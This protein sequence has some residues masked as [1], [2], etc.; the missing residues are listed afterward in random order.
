MYAPDPRASVPGDSAGRRSEPIPV[1]DDEHPRSVFLGPYAR[2]GRGHG[3]G[4]GSGSDGRGQGAADRAARRDDPRSGEEGAGHRRRPGRYDR[5]A[6]PGRTGVRVHSCGAGGRVRR[7]SPESL[8][9]PDRRGCRGLSEGSGGEGGV[10][11]ADSGPHG[12]GDRGDPGIRGELRSYA[13]L[14]RRPGGDRT[15]RDHR[16]H[17]RGGVQAVGISIWRG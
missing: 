5:G 4:E 11:S 10:E 3:E 13:G 17:R 15:W 16:G 6:E 1:R 2:A 7:Q 12:R 8:L 9:H 14:E